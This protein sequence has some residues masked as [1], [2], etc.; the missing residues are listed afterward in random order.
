MPPAVPGDAQVRAVAV[1]DEFVAEIVASARAR[2]VLVPAR[3]FDWASGE[4]SWVVERFVLRCLPLAA[5]DEAGFDT[6]LR[7]AVRYWV[8]PY[9]VARF[10]QLRQLFPEL[11]VRSEGPHVSVLVRTGRWRCHVAEAC[12][13]RLCER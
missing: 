8:A 11:E 5:G 9:L 6:A 1:L 13:W 10:A 2:G 7:C 12:A 3:L 4:G